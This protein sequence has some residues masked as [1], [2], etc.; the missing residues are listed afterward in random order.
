MVGTIVVIDVQQ[1]ANEVV[2][3]LVHRSMRS[4]FYDLRAGVT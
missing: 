3:V 2:I 4:L 1:I